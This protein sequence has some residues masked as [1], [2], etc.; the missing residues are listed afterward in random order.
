MVKRS[1]LARKKQQETDK[2]PDPLTQ[3][4]AQINIRVSEET[5]VWLEAQA[6]SKRAVPA[7]VRDLI[8]RERAGERAKEL[9]AMFNRAALDLTEDDREERQLFMR[10]HPKRGPR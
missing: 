3:G 10:A 2:P 9:L 7:Y 5:R 4:S 8:E 6:G 1:E